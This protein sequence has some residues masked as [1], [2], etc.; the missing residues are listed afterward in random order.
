MDILAQGDGGIPD[1]PVRDYPVPRGCARFILPVDLRRALHEH[2]LTRD[3]YPRASGHYSRDPGH[4]T[5]L[6]PCHLIYYCTGG[7]MRLRSDA[8]ES[9]LASGDIAIQ[10]PGWTQLTGTEGKPLSLYWVAFSGS[11][12]AVYSQFIDSSDGVVHLGPDPG[13]IGQFETLCRLHDLQRTDF[14]ID[15][16]ING[17]SLLK[18]L[19]TSIPVLLSHRGTER[20][21][22]IQMERIRGFMAQRIGEPLRLEDMARSV[23]LS[24]Y[25]FA[26]TFKTLTGLAPMQYFIRMRLQQACRLLDTTRLPVKQISAAVGYPDPQHFSRRFCQAFGMAPLAYRNRAS[27]CKATTSGATP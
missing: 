14:T 4:G 26:R 24:P 5:F 23:N 6:Q 21:D 18:A 10:P 8:G 11:L 12:S 22:R 25:H 2:P 15:R 16:F 20:R 9:L 3:L 1:F 17:A 27:A 19:L 7:K 13:L